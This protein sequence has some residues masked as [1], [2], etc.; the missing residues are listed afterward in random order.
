MLAEEHSEEGRTE[1]GKEE[2]SATR[3]R[4]GDATDGCASQRRGR[5]CVCWGGIK[6]KIM[7][8]FGFILVRI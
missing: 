5:L 4:R 1:E 8:R 3:L 6:R 2:K 7:M